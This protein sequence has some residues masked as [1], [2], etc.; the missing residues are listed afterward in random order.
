MRNPASIPRHAAPGLP[1]ARPPV[2]L[3]DGIAWLCWVVVVVAAGASVG[4]LF[5]PGAWYDALAKPTWHPPAWLF[6]PVWT[7]LYAL[8]GTGVWLV[9]R[10][11]GPAAEAARPQ[12]WLAFGVQAV[13]NLAWTPLFFGLRSPASAFVDIVLLWGAVLW[14]TLAFGRVRPLA[15]TLQVPLVAWVSFAL[16][17]NGTLW[18]MN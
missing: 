10:E 13:L 2:R 3:R 7:L 14:M 18:L 6:G 4:V 5:S 1:P 12:A 11:P 9:S 8:L 16:V 17:L 15:G